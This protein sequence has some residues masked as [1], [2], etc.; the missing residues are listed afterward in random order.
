M[1]RNMPECTS[2]AIGGYFALELP[3]GRAWHAGAVALNSGR[4]AL[5]YLL[6]SKRP[7]RIYIPHFTCAAI[8]DVVGSMG[9]GIS[10]YRIDEAMEPLFDFSAVA[11]DE[12]FLYT[13]Y[14]GLKDHYTRGLAALGCRIIVDNAQSF[15]SPHSRDMEYFYSPRKFFGV[16]DGGY[17][18]GPS[19]LELESDYSSRRAAHL[20]T[21]HDVSAQAGYV[22]YQ[23]NEALIGELPMRAMSALSARILDSVDYA[24]AAKQRQQNFQFLH[25]ALGGFN[26]LPICNDKERVALSYP[27]LCND[28]D[29]RGRLHAHNIHT[30]TYWPDEAQGADA[31]SVEHRYIT[32]L[33]HLPIDQRYGM[34]EM[35]SILSVVLA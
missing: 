19:S 34:A 24:A 30:A 23:T 16:P 15:F 18:Y 14:F 4:N 21:R 2:P 17:A 32:Q 3:R 5:R 25:A 8:R 12:A 26:A 35:E 29:L 6:A 10:Q 11:A 7:R 33:V 9:I 13:N 22:S 31:A 28:T 1:A 20:L 27:M